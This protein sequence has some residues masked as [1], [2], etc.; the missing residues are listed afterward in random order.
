MLKAVTYSQKRGLINQLILSVSLVVLL[1][2]IFPA[3]TL[4]DPPDP[5]SADTCAKCHEEETD[6]WRDSPHAKAT[7]AKDRTPGATCES[8]HG[9]YAENHPGQDL[10]QLSVNSS[11][12]QD[13]HSSTFDQW[14]HSQHG[15]AGVQCISCHLSHSQHFRL[16]DEAMCSSC[17]EEDLEDFFHTAHNTSEV[18]C[19]DCHVSSMIPQGVAVASTEQS[20]G[21]SAVPSHDF[22]DVSSASCVGCHRHNVRD[23]PS[24]YTNVDWVAK[25]RL[26]AQA[27]RVPELASELE[28]TQQS[29]K[30]L[31]TLVPV[32]LG[33][34]IG[35]GGMLG[36]VAM[37]VLGYV[38]RRRTQ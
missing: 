27:H 34:G 33:L 11:V 6:A 16:T 35:I 4:A 38:S 20:S 24:S 23:E 10:M 28:T 25:S 2:L 29:N 21:P 14:E 26:I 7:S 12:C 36:I 3:T 15:Q 1:G 22:A 5:E 18:P 30:S 9:S 17:H 13:C 32:S 8:C 19:T 31:Q 37:L